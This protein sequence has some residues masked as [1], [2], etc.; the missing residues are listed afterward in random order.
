MF[1]TWLWKGT[2]SSLLSMYCNMT[3]CDRYLE[4]ISSQSLPSHHDTVQA[5]IHGAES[6][7]EVQRPP[8]RYC[9]KF[10]W[11]WCMVV[12]SHEWCGLI[13][14]K[15]L[16][17]SHI[18]VPCAIAASSWS[19]C[20]KIKG[21]CYAAAYSIILFSPLW[22]SFINELGLR[23]GGGGKCIVA[24]IFSSNALVT[25]YLSLCEKMK[26][27]C[28]LVVHPSKHCTKLFRSCNWCLKIVDSPQ[29]FVLDRLIVD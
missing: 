7:I 12:H 27:F 11:T 25:V 9:T 22:C 3:I 5:M 24:G 13:V 23:F 21:T 29:Y 26:T 18:T 6:R 16:Y 15:R 14:E 4:S 8:D 10:H 20:K 19:D 2:F 1:S 28:E 17:L